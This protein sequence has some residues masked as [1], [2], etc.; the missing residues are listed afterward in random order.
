MSA[1][2]RFLV[3]LAFFYTCVEGLVVNLLY[4][5][6]LP[7]LYKDF[8]LLAVYLGVVVP[9][10]E[11][12]LDPPPQL[13]ILAAFL[14]LFGGLLLVYLLIP[15]NL[16]TLSQLVA[17]KQRLFYVPLIMVG[18]FFTRSSDD[19]KALIT[20]MA[21]Y[22]IGVSLFGIYLYFAG[23]EGLTSLGARYSAVFYTPGRASIWRVPGTFTSSGQY[24]AYLSL[25]AILVA[26]L[27][28]VP[29]VTRWARVTVMV[30][31]VLIVLAMLASGSRS[32]IVVASAGVSLATLM[33]GRLTR[34]GLWALLGYAVLAYG[35]VALGPGVQERFDSIA[36]A[37]HVTRF[38]QTYFGQLFLPRLLE[39]PL[40]QGL[41][42]AT[43]GARHFSEYSQIVFMESYLG[44]LAVEAGLPGL[45]AF[46]CVA[47]A[48]VALVVTNHRLMGRAPDGPL[49]LAFASY[50]ILTVGVMPVSTSIDH[51]PSNFYFW[52]AIGALVRLVELEYWRT[53][54]LKA[55][56]TGA[57]DRGETP[58]SDE[59]F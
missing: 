30:S 13:R 29:G 21:V 26:A 49:W 54:Y 47:G 16:T 19:L 4:P 51:T 12:M 2:V 27:L 41:G 35:F 7:F 43:I 10:L 25:N 44:I 3:H 37:E 22:A 53:Y 14:G 1:L 36:S 11:R 17:V 23:P 55:D 5:A 8:V 32:S 34:V 48:I 52:F 39:H 6:T 40:G 33:S 24:G 57:V 38:Q 59:S 56:G 20:A 58:A 50:V 31:L 15:S 42:V 28:F 18:Y 45:L 9:N 46:L